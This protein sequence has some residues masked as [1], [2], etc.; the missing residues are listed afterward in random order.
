[1]EVERSIAAPLA[2]GPVDYLF[3][4]EDR[5]ICVTEGKFNEQD[6]G[7]VQNIAQLSA[8]RGEYSCKR[9]CE[10]IS[11]DDNDLGEDA[12]FYGIA[13]TYLTW[14]F[15][16][17]QNKKVKVSPLVTIGVGSSHLADDVKRVTELVAGMLERLR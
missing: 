13:T 17:L 3:K 16:V 8:A 9:K 11:E 4:C 2:N 10:E 14:Q 1:M 5:V 6:E 12:P 15:K 7:V